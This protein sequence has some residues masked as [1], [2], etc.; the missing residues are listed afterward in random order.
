MTMW[1]ARYRTREC[2]YGEEANDFLASVV[3]RLPR[4]Y[5]LSPGENAFGLLMSPNM[6]IEFGDAFDNKG[7]NFR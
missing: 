5:T 2:V 7:A 1:D 4:G 6:L 3:D